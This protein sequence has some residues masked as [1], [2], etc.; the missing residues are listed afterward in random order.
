MFALE[1]ILVNGRKKVAVTSYP[2]SI[3]AQSA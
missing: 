2:L 3:S 1:E